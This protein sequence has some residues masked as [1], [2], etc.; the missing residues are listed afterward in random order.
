MMF[1]N[2]QNK[3][4]MIT[5]ETSYIKIQLWGKIVKVYAL[6]DKKKLLL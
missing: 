1:L 4:Y 3:M 6:Q 5:M 2:A